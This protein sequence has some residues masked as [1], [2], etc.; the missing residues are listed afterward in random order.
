MRTSWS[1]R[2][3]GAAAAAVVFV[4]A[5][6]TAACGSDKEAK[7]PVPVGTTAHIKVFQFTPNPLKVKVGTTVTWVNDDDIAHTVTS[8]TRD[9]APG[10]SGTVTAVHADGQF[11]TTLDGAGK[12]ATFTFTK[13]GTFHYFCDRHPGMEAE[14]VVAETAPSGSSD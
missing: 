13:A 4:A 10:D 1:V 2:R 7:A 3:G 14:V 11:D 6:S 12:K 5:M 9:Y 8:G